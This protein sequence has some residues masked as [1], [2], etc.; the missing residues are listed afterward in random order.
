MMPA[1]RPRSQPL[2]LES[3]S[4]TPN[5]KNTRLV[6]PIAISRTGFFFSVHLDRNLGRFQADI[7]ILEIRQV[8]KIHT[9]LF[10]IGSKVRVG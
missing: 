8:F 9:V 5:V 10:V 7:K 1:P 4:S 6:F 2:C 3:R